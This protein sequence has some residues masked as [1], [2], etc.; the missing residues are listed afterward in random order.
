[1]ERN[2]L[3]AD[4]AGRSARRLGMRVVEVD[5]SLD[6]EAVADLVAD[7]FAP[8]LNLAGREQT[9]K[10]AAGRSEP[11]RACARRRHQRMA[12][13]RLLKHAL[14][15]LVVEIAPR[16]LLWVKVCRWGEP[17]MAVGA[18]VYAPAAV[19]MDQSM[20]EGTD[21]DAVG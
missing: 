6:A 9:Q 11:S 18:D 16:G 7:H 12:M 2:R 3:I 21:Q 14:V 10:A 17:G 20:M 4:D 19:S 1:M 13:N 5:G 15:A 8:F